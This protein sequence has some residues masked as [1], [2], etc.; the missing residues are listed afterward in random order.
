MRNPAGEGA[1]GFHFVGLLELDFQAF[2][3]DIMFRI[4]NRTSDLIADALHQREG[5]LVVGVRLHRPEIEKPNHMIMHDE[6][7]NEMRTQSGLFK[8][9][10]ASKHLANRCIIINEH[11]F[12]SGR[13]SH[14]FC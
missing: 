9:Q 11:E 13:T 8:R 10:R 7:M 12:A 5:L 4:G 6:G 2:T 14:F 3:L 1:D